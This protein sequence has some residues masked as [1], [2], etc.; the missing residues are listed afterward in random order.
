[1]GDAR[2]NMIDPVRDADSVFP[3][4][5]RYPFFLHLEG[6]SPLGEMERLSHFSEKEVLHLCYIF[7][8]F[9]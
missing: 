5:A 2:C 3:G 8:T 7:V 9:L 6:D 1:M 4:H